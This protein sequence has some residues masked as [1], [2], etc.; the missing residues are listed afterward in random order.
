MES[1][2][3]EE[4]CKR[5][6]QRSRNESGEQPFFLQG[7]CR[8]RW[9]TEPLAVLAARVPACPDPGGPGCRALY[10]LSS[11]AMCQVRPRGGLGAAEEGPGGT[12][13]HLV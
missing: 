2:L 1:V 3:V 6:Q 10:N 11:G 12:S 7:H 9:H 8:L 13:P 4:F 5:F